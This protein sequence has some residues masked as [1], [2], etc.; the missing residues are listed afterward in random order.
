MEALLKKYRDVFASSDY[1][2]CSTMGQHTI[3]LTTEEPITCRPRR[4]PTRWKTEIDEE[5]RRL[6]KQNIIR[7]ST[8]AYAAP[9]CPVRKKDGSLRLCVDYRALNAKAESTAIPTGNLNEVV[10]SMSGAKFFSTI[11][12]ARG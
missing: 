11:D 8:S 10:E 6:H 2:G 12:L 1:T 3:P 9:I 5:V 4:L 7:P